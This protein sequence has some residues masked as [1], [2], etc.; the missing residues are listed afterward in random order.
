L[1]SGGQVSLEEKKNTKKGNKA[2]PTGWLKRKRKNE[3]LKKEARWP[4]KMRSDERLRGTEKQA[5]SKI[6]TYV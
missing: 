2:W 6:N 4:K 3:K 1:I 5:A